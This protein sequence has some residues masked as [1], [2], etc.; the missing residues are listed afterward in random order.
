MGGNDFM[1]MEQQQKENFGKLQEILQRK[2][3]NQIILGY[4]KQLHD[5]F[6]QLIIIDLDWADIL[7]KAQK[8]DGDRLENALY[9]F[10]KL[11]DSYDE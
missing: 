5:I 1:D 7:C 6:S 8:L 2:G 10:V 4:I 11:V 3:T 9:Q